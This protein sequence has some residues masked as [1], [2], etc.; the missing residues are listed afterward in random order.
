MSAKV[1]NLNPV[2]LPDNPNLTSRGARASVT[3]LNLYA[4]LKSAIILK[5][6]EGATEIGY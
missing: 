5:F 6:S 1:P 2:Y 4:I 3:P